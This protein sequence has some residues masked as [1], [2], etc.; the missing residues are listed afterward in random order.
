MPREGRSKPFTAA[1]DQPSAVTLAK[2]GRLAADGFLPI[3]GE[4]RSAF[5]VSGLVEC[6]RVRLR[7]YQSHVWGWIGDPL[8]V[9]GTVEEAGS[10]SLLR[11]SVAAERKPTN[12]WG[13]LL[14]VLLLGAG[15]VAVWLPYQRISIAEVV[16]L[17]AVALIFVIA[18]GF[19]GELV[20]ELFTL[21][22][23]KTI[24]ASLRAI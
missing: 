18:M 11:G 2:L 13:V 17:W 19:A 10:T 6:D 7:L 21:R 8:I 23:A 16:V 9:Q 24:A 1:F 4:T 3:P 14:A 20:T 22:Q 5:G 12:W 15:M